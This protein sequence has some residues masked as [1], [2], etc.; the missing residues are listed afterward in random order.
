MMPQYPHLNVLEL[1]G[2]DSLGD[3]PSPSGRH[4]GHG[5][6]MPRIREV[7]PALQRGALRFFCAG[8]LPVLNSNYGNATAYQIPLY[9]RVGARLSF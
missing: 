1:P 2:D 9:M 4:A 8:A 3:D 7:L 6:G 5:G